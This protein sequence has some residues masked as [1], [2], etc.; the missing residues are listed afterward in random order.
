MPLKFALPTLVGITLI[1]LSHV[2]FADDKVTPPA[3]SPPSRCASKIQEHLKTSNL[4][5][6]DRSALARILDDATIFSGSD[7][8]RKKGI[9]EFSKRHYAAEL[10]LLEREG[11]AFVI[12]SNFETCSGAGLYYRQPENKLVLCAAKEKIS[13][14]EVSQTFEHEFLHF[15]QDH[16]MP[17]KAELTRRYLEVRRNGSRHTPHL[18]CDHSRAQNLS[19][20]YRRVG[21]KLDALMKN[22]TP[23]QKR[24]IESLDAL[25]P[26]FS[27]DFS[28][29]GSLSLDGKFGS[30]SNQKLRETFAT[31]IRKAKGNRETAALLLG[32]DFGNEFA[33][34]FKA[35]PN[36]PGHCS[37]E[38]VKDV[39]DCFENHKQK[40]RDDVKR[41]WTQ[42]EMRD[43][44]DLAYKKN[45]CIHALITY[46]DEL[47]ANAQS[48]VRS[49]NTLHLLSRHG[50]K[51]FCHELDTS[52]VPGLESSD[53]A[54]DVAA[55]IYDRTRSSI[56]KSAVYGGAFSRFGGYSY[57]L[58]D[59]KHCQTPPDV[60]FFERG[61]PDFD[62]SKAKDAVGGSSTRS[63]KSDTVR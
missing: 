18:L 14:H 57:P 26:F 21:G 25:E 5:A 55:R 38:S 34:A 49:Y 28:A 6:E 24:L 27:I 36:A 53:S 42:S 15:L 31:I 62:P 11:V 61:C 56:S 33:D 19:A 22:T 9:A 60:D 40:I 16:N 35:A 46:C 50:L 13:G 51:S 12:D 1:H 32:V 30:N 43:L 4:T 41:Q 23:A 54:S 8:D 29:D 48:S 20:H 58:F 63:Q 59:V 44:L 7:A 3:E 10:A 45:R 39:E 52:V 17:E 37:M 47:Q 2:A